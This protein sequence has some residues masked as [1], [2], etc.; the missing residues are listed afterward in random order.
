MFS[1]RLHWNLTPNQLLETLAAKRAAGIDILDLTESNP[2]RA[3]FVYD[4]TEILRAL[5]QPKSLLYQP[6]P[7]GLPAARAA[8]A[9]YYRDRGREID[10][11]SIFL[12]ASTSEAYGWLFKLLADPGDEI[13]VPQPGYPLFDFLTAL[14]SVRQIPY[15]LRYDD[16]AGWQINFERLQAAI[17][18]RTRAIVAVNPNNPAGV[19][20]KQRELAALNALCAERRLAL[21]VDEVFSDYGCGKDEARVETTAGNEGALTFVLSGLSKVAGLPQVKLGWIQISGPQTVAA[22]SASRLE[23]IADAYLSASAS[24]QHAAPILLASRSSI[25]QQIIERL[26]SNHRWLET[27]ARASLRRVLKREGGWYAVMDFADS[28]ADSDRAQRWLE[29]FNVFV[30]PG[31]FY[32]FAREGFAV[33]SLLTPPQTFMAGIQRLLAP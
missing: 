13:L 5:A 30:H 20:L 1:S 12:A 9:D 6:S 21:I 18:P 25:Q 11:D 2:T 10:P 31:Y 7:R 23:F 28:V 16:S 17:G 26:D 24:V 8:V 14:E 29:E 15:P 22:E 4:D 19:F 33:V 27:R 3:G 32:D